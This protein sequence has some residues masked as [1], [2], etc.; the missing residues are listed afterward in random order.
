MAVTAEAA[1]EYD[2]AHGVTDRGVLG[3]GT[4]RRILSGGCRPAD[5][6]TWRG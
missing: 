3:F 6:R 4:A 1:G 5:G 2:S